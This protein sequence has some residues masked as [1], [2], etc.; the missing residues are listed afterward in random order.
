M[1]NANLDLIAYPNFWML[2]AD[3]NKPFRASETDN[4]N[5][6]IKCREL[7]MY[8]SIDRNLEKDAAFV[9]DWDANKKQYANILINEEEVRFKT[10]DWAIKPE[11]D[12]R[13]HGNQ[14]AYLAG[15]YY[16]HP[17]DGSWLDATGAGMIAAYGT[18]GNAHYGDPTYLFG[19]FAHRITAKYDDVNYQ[20]KSADG[21]TRYAWLDQSTTPAT[22][23]NDAGDVVVHY[24]VTSAEWVRDADSAVVTSSLWRILPYAGTKIQVNKVKSTFDATTIFTG[25]LHYKVY[26]DIA[27]GVAGPGYPAGN[28]PV[29]DWQY[30]DLAEL[31][32][33]ADAD[34]YI[35]PMTRD[36]HT[37]PIMI[38]SYDYQAAT[39]TPVI[40]SLLNM[41]LDILLSDNTPV[42]GTPNAHATFICMK[43][44]SI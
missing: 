35:E 15:G 2:R 12:G 14:V 34:P 28:Y 32:S 40:D 23:K 9:A 22:W 36:G 27:E 6:T 41:H 19:A 37:G 39:K 38:L 7:E 33:G 1:S 31:A 17:I 10:H 18:P 16:M 13:T 20:W 11:W 29:R 42:T 5:I 3:Q 24:D 8:C 26:M 21:A 25:A 43:I 30:A 44:Q 4:G